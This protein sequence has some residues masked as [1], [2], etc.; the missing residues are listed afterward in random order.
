MINPYTRLSMAAYHITGT[1]S[2]SEFFLTIITKIE[3]FIG[4]INQR[5]P[6]YSAIK[7]NGKRAYNIARSGKIPE[8]KK[9]KV[10]ID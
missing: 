7:I 1:M 4:E 3:K 6:Y 5:P 9:R 10:T 8:L 2:K